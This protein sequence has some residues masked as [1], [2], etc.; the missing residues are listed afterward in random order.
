VC[1]DSTLKQVFS[2]GRRDLG[3]VLRQDRSGHLDQCGE[4]LAPGFDVGCCG[5]LFVW[6]TLYDGFS[7]I[8]ELY[9]YRFFDQFI[10]FT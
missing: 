9:D 7:Q 3:T 2:P 8:Y 6:G 10:A 5:G 1:G 4:S